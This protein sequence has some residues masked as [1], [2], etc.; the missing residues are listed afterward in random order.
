MK[1]EILDFSF[2]YLQKSSVFLVYIVQQTHAYMYTHTS[3]KKGKKTTQKFHVMKNRLK[4][5]NLRWYYTSEFSKARAKV[6]KDWN[7]SILLIS[8]ATL[9]AYLFSKIRKIC[10]GQGMRI[11]NRLFNM[12]KTW[13]FSPNFTKYFNRQFC[14]SPT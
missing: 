11:L 10:L 8:K 13:F 12:Y 7:W 9:I 5:T 4:L 2:S 3:S 6:S 1:E 14:Y